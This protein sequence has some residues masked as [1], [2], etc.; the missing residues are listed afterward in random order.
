MQTFVQFK[1][2]ELRKFSRTEV[3]RVG[4]L[5]RMQPQ[6][7]LEVGSAAEAFLAYVALVRFLARVHQVVLL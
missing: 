3:A 7:G 5:A 4:F 1:V 2:D 6:V